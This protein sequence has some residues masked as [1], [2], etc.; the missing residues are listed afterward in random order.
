MK[1]LLIVMGLLYVSASSAS[2]DATTEDEKRYLI[3]IAQELKHLDGLA[4]KAANKAD[5]DARVTLDYVALRHDL[6]EMQRALEAHI[7]NPS[8]TP[9]RIES[10]TLARK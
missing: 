2:T 3:K 10:L 1:C 8:R 9:R 6:Q 4:V 7:N 5:P